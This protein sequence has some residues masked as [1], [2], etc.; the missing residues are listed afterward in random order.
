MSEPMSEAK[1]EESTPQVP[2]ETPAAPAEEKKPE[3][4]PR[5]P[6]SPEEAAKRKAERAEKRKEARQKAK[7]AAKEAKSAG[8]KAVEI[9]EGAAPKIT[10]GRIPSGT[11][12]AELKALF[13]P[14]GTIL[15]A[16]VSK[17]KGRP[18]IGTVLFNTIGDVKRAINGLHGK[19][20]FADEEE[21][22]T[23]QFSKDAKTLGESLKKCTDE[24][25]DK[26]REYKYK[27]GVLRSKDAKDAINRLVLTKKNVPSG[28]LITAVVLVQTGTAKV[29]DL[30]DAKLITSA[31]SVNQLLQGEIKTK[32]TAVKAPAAKA[33]KKEEAT[34]A[35]KVDK[36]FDAVVPH[37]DKMEKDRWNRM[38]KANLRLNERHRFRFV[39]ILAT[40][41]LE[42]WRWMV[43]DC[44]MTPA[45]AGTCFAILQNYYGFSK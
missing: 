30:V 9:P 18:T 29:Q 33:V 12:A 25:A 41:S 39:D 16:E 28:D 15:R 42:L 2:E 35:V 13:E 21:A 37:L 43:E 1:P 10:V 5:E 27:P 17:R 26:L 7:Q 40:P 38:A 31:A 14:F 19:H 44:D 8:P 22:V 24:V 4:K 23:I 34:P 32:E 6:L 20:K 36:T 11:T 45:E 3:K